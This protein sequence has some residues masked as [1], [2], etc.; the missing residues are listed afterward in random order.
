MLPFAYLLRNLLRRGTRTAVT[1]AGVA[2]TTMLVIAMHAFAAGM[3][4]AATGSARED[5]VL[6]IGV[7]SEVDVVRSVIARGSAEVAAAAAPGVR[8]ID[9]RRAASVEL[10]IATRNG[11]QIGLLRGITPAAYLVHDRVQV[12]EGREPRASMEV[13]VGALAGTRMGLPEADLAVGKTLHV[14]R[15]D[16]TIVGRFA[17]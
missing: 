17:A 14:E 13:M 9:G 4:G 12:I 5:A 2:A 6:L 16:F 7:S 1:I 15:T 3:D 10:H 11:E 8:T